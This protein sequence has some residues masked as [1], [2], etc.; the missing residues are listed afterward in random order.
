ML[1]WDVSSKPQRE[2]MADQQP[3]DYRKLQALD[4][5]LRQQQ[6]VERIARLRLGSAAVT[7]CGTSM[8][9]TVNPASWR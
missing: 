5:A 7:T 3:V 8:G 1:N 9:K 4:L 2:R 6:P